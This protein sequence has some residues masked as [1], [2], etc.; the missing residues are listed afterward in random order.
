VQKEVDRAAR[1]ADVAIRK[2]HF[3]H[4]GGE[5]NFVFEHNIAIAGSV[6]AERKALEAHRKALEKQLEA[7][8]QRLE[9]LD[10]EEEEISGEDRQKKSNVEKDEAVLEETK[11]SLPPDS[12]P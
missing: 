6:K 7:I 8:D 10:D 2:F 9:K 5:D 11:P 1:E 4:P 3:A 12:A